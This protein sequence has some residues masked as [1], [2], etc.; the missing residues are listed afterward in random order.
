MSGMNGGRK[1]KLTPSRVAWAREQW[2]LAMP[3]RD[4]TKKLKI[5]KATLYLYAKR[6]DFGPHPNRD[7]SYQV[8]GCGQN[9]QTGNPQPTQWRCSC[10]GICVTGPS[11]TQ[12]EAA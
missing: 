4:L 7:H 1:E 9:K 8:R 12:C 2:Q 10:G 3:V 11:H 5:N 6:Y